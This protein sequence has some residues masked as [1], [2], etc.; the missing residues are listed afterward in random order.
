MLFNSYVFL[1]AFFPVV[2]TAFFLTGRYGFEWAGRVLALA[3]LVF[4]LGGISGLLRY[5]CSR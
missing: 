3:S 4:I 5:F 1:F 2:V